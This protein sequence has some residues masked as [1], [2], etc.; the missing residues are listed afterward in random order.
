[1]KYYEKAAEMDKAD[2]KYWRSLFK[3][4]KALGMEEKTKEAQKKV[5]QL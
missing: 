5:K 2:N 4:Y 3:V 1:M